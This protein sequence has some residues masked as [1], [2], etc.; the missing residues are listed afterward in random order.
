MRVAAGEMTRSMPC[1]PSVGSKII[2]R[3]VVR[4]PTGP[5]VTSVPGA[6]AQ[7]SASK[8]SGSATTNFP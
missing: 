7:S 5:A 2:G 3:I 8:A 4:I 6:T 1:C